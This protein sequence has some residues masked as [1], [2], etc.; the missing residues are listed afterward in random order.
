MGARCQICDGPVVNGRC[1]LCGMPYRKDEILYHL[2]ESRSE[3]YKHATDA[4]RKRMRE[5]QIPVQ[6]RKKTADTTAKRADRMSGRTTSGSSYGRMAQTNRYGRT[7]AGSMARKAASGNTFGKAGTADKK[8]GKKNSW[9]SLVF[10]LVVLGGTVLPRGVEYIKSKMEPA[11][12]ETYRDGAID[13]SDMNIYAVM[14]WENNV[15]ETGASV[16]GQSV[17]PGL[18]VLKNTEGT[19][20]V[21]VLSWENGEETYCEFDSAGEYEILELHVRDSIHLDVSHNENSKVLLYQI[22]QYDE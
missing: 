18:Y 12:S 10:L 16:N 11:W 5:N 15:L 13:I 1:K 4:A 17:E 14:N 9:L 19:A 22:E 21:M 7:D 8:S 20:D 3:H 2:N 6:D